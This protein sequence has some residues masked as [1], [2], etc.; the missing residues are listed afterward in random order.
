MKPYFKYHFNSSLGI[1]F[2]YYYGNITLTDIENSWHYAFQ[3]NLIT[4]NVTGF[5]LDY[6]EAN[7]NINPEDFYKISD[8][9]KQNINYFNHK[10][11]GIVTNNPKDVVIPMLV[12]TK[13]EG[14]ASHPFSTIESAIDWVLL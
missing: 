7:L 9:Y 10:K 1:L 14:Y 5:V 4:D 11:I 8:F 2:K 6:S 3:N 13:D 12:E